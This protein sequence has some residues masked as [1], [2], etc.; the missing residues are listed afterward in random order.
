[1]RVIL[2][3]CSSGWVGGGKTSKFL[4]SNMDQSSLWPTHFVSHPF[5]F[6]GLTRV[7]LGWISHKLEW[8][9]HLR[10]LSKLLDD[11]DDCP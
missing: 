4:G 9:H 8:H 2:A 1:M 10:T 5:L 7:T 6:G 11:N 3:P